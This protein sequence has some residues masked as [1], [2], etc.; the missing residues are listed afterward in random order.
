MEEWVK[1][2]DY[3]YSISRNGEVRND[4]RE[5]L[6]KWRIDSDGYYNIGLSKNNKKKFYKI[7]RLIAIYFIP[8]PNN[9]LEIDHINNNPIDNSIENLR[10]CNRSQNNRN[11]KKR[12]NTTSSFI[13]VTFYKQTNKWIARCRLNGKQKHIGMY[14]T[15]IE[16]AIAYNNFII[17][18][19][20]DDFNNINIL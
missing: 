11:R 7:H 17:E 12:E 6:L 3:E 16:A 14:K 18:N 9:Y 15:E 20:L 8:N 10:W 1:I 5:R 19:N 4:K 2:E 13:G